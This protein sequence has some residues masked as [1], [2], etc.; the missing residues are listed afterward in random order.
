MN[1]AKAALGVIMIGLSFIGFG[2]TYD[3]YGVLANWNSLSSGTD[4]HD[5]GSGLLVILPALLAIFSLM[6]MLI[7]AAF[8]YEQL[9]TL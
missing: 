1:W 5:V 3:V 4:L 6:F 9:D 2:L 8:L 7:G